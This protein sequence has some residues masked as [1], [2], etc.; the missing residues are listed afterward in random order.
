MNPDDYLRRADGYID[1]LRG[2]LSRFVKGRDSL[3]A[4]DD[5]EP[6]IQQIT[7][8]LRDLFH[9]AMG[10]N[11]YSKMVIDAYNHGVA[12]LYDSPSYSSVERIISIAS[13]ARNR[14]E[15]NPELLG[16][17]QPGAATPVPAPLAV[18]DKVTLRWLFNHVPYS[19]WFWLGSL[20]LGAF[21]LGAAA[22]YKL[23]LVQQ[24]LGVSCTH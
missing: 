14:V 9:D 12:N 22:V 6:R 19:F 23:Q 21:A 1:E 16:N 4:A 10:Q 5:D 18:P 3:L 7:L 13:A 20:M 11:D 17:A 15:N 8:E 24:W 2:I